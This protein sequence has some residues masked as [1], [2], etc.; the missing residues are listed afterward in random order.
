VS[1]DKHKCPVAGCEEQMPQSKLMC[2]THW[3]A[4]P[5]PLQREVN[6]TWRV[7]RNDVQYWQE[8]LEARQA[9]IESV[10]GMLT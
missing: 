1:R 6:R 10:S 7:A 5:M 8:Y 9:A 4:V 2:L 3:R